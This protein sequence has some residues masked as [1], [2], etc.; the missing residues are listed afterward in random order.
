MQQARGGRSLEREPKGAGGFLRRSFRRSKSAERL[1]KET[2]AFQRDHTSASLGGGVKRPAYER[3][4]QRPPGFLRPVAIVGLFCDTVRDRLAQDSPGLF[5]RA[6]PEVEMPST[7]SQGGGRQGPRPRQPQTHPRHH[8][9]TQTLPH[10]SLPSS[11]SVPPTNPTPPHSDLPSPR[12]QDG[13]QGPEVAAPRLALRS[14]SS[15]M[16]EEALTFERTYAHLFTATVTYT[17]DDGWFTLL[18]DTINRIQNQPLW[19][20]APKVVPSSAET[21]P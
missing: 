20:L 7:A 21:V 18:K 1:N 16:Y 3:V 17:T 9:Q 2:D 11:H 12:Q 6:P 19:Q 4:E 8:R 15:F 10:D 5:E 13:D 14:G